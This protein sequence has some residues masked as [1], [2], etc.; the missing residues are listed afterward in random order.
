[1]YLDRFNRAK[2]DG[3]KNLVS[4]EAHLAREERLREIYSHQI[5]AC[6]DAR[7]RR[8][9]FAI[10]FAVFDGSFVSEVIDVKPSDLIFPIG[11]DFQLHTTRQVDGTFLYPDPQDF[12][13]PLKDVTHLRIAGFHMWDCVQRVARCAHSSGLDVL[14][15]EDL[16]ELFPGMLKQP[17]FRVDRYPT[18]NPRKSSK[19]M[20]DFFMKARVNKPWLWQNY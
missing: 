8:N 20:F 15:D 3:E 17:E 16:T 7:Y 11:M 2:T 1:M 13:R 19:A 5:N 9:G 6:I 12:L 14:V 10:S 18:Y 4:Q